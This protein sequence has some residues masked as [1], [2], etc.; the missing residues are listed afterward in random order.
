MRC[1]DDTECLLT[2]GVPVEITVELWSTAM[3]FNAGHRIRISVSGSNSPRFEV[4]PNNGANL[5]LETSPIVARPRLLVGGD[6]R[7]QLE[8][9]LLPMQRHAGGRRQAMGMGV[10]FAP[11]KSDNGS[12]GESDSRRWIREALIRAMLRPVG[13]SPATATLHKTR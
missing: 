13:P 8:L 5:N 9:P 7:S 2:P 12:A 4:N 6:H 10:R 1:G 3:V 11:S